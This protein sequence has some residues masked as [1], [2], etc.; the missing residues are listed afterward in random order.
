MNRFTC[1]LRGAGRAFRTLLLI[2]L[3]LAGAAPVGFPLAAQA[4][5]KITVTGRILDA[6]Q[7]PLPGASVVLKGTKTG[8]SADVDGNYSISFTPGTNN[9][10]IFSFIGME[11]QEKQVSSSTRL[12]I[13]LKSDTQL[14]AVVVNGF[15]T[16]AKETFTGAATTISG[17]E[18]AQIAPTN[19]LQG[20]ATLTPNMVI[21]ENNAAGSNPNVVP[22]ILIRGANSLITNESEVGINNPLVVLDGVEITLSELYDLDIFDIERVDVLKDASATILYGE[23]G[24]NGVIV[25]ERK[26]I[27]ED[28]VKLTYNFVPQ[29]S[30][31]DLSSYH[32]TDSAQKLEVERLSGL[33]NVANAPG[34]YDEAYAWKQ[35]QIRKGVNTNWMKTPLRIPFSHNHSLA[36]SSRGDKLEFRANA[37]FNDSYGVMKGDNHR[38]VGVNFNIGYHLRDKLTLSYKNSFSMNNSVNSPY[39]NFANYVKMNPY[40]QVYDEDGELIRMYWFDPV[41]QTGTS[42]AN[43]LYDATLS[44]FSKNKSTTFNNSLSGRWNVTKELYVTA[45]GNVGLGWSTADTYVSPETA[46]NLLKTDISQR[47]EYSYRST[48]SVKASGNVVVNYGRSL[49]VKGSMFRVSA[50]SN[51]NYSHSQTAGMKA[52]GFLKDE[53][54]DLKFAQSYSTSENRPSGADNLSTSAGFFING[55]LGFRNRYFADVSYRLSA[56]SQ[57]GQDQKFTPFWAVGAGWNIHREAFARDWSWLNSLILRYSAGFTGSMN[58]SSYQAKTIYEYNSQY[59]Y[60]TGIGALQNQMGNPDLKFQRTFQ[61]NIGL[62]A[63]FVDNRFN[64]S[65]DWFVKTT[66]D[67]VMSIELPPSVG[68][69]T[70]SVNFG[71]LVNQGF[72]IRLSAQI[73]KTR[74]LYWST[75]FSGGHVFDQIR[76]I[77]SS[78]K[79]TE[80]TYADEVRPKLLFQEGGSQFDIYLMRSAGIDPATGQEIFIRKNGEYTFTYNPDDRVPVGNTNP[81]LRGSWMNS[82]RYKN[83]TFNITTTYEFGADYYNSTIAS[84]VEDINPEFNVDER[85]FTDRWKQ[86]GDIVRYLSLDNSI[87]HRQS[88][89]FVE[90]RNELNISSIQVLYDF[91]PGLLSR[92]GMRKLVLGFG[93]S[94]VAHFSTVKYERGTSYPYCRSFNLIFRPTF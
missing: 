46:A 1:S 39:G 15:Y 50:G 13:S 35:E 69:S 41:N 71:E 94:D 72:D 11:S 80:H 29:Y 30:I 59:Q 57:F 74:D 58:F 6:D 54:S 62:T 77:S 26:H 61:H 40:W 38:N 89:R 79:N 28:R 78:L 12:D 68:V 34:L 83:F 92:F 51:I 91:Q 47:G 81:I 85:V 87:T 53:L 25:V 64:L 56:S 86:P 63:A 16:Q 5:A 70:M 3:L 23:K 43:P 66:K 9:V 84:K 60:F 8:V 76:K 45:Q 33:Y 93:L 37:N 4:P 49:D 19:I 42:I 17:E 55:N 88:E 67:Q 7:Q 75:T 27:S 21:V 31:P 65:F 18:I 14:D 90:R 82:F 73:I 32:M 20:I 44:S 2:G 36:L 52:Q 48:N 10:L 24:A 22:D